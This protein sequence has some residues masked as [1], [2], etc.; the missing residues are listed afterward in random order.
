VRID[1]LMG[2]SHERLLPRVSRGAIAS[3]TIVLLVAVV[4]ALGQ[5]ARTHLLTLEF[6]P[7]AAGA[8]AHLCPLPIRGPLL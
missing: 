6:L 4:I 5:A 2:V 3:T 1:Q 8:L 7:E